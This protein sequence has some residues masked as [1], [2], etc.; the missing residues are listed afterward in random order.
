MKRAEFEFW[1]NHC[2]LIVKQSDFDEGIYIS[3]YNRNGKEEYFSSQ[4]LT[5]RLNNTKVIV[6]DKKS[7]HIILRNF[8]MMAEVIG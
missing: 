8:K 7:K 2:D 1:T 5:T 6:L 3:M 4:Q